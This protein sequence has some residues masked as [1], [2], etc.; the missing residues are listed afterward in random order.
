MFQDVQELRSPEPKLAVLVLCTVSLYKL[1]SELFLTYCHL[2]WRLRYH[3]GN[4]SKSVAKKVNL[5]SF[6]LYRDY[7]NLLT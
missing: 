1:T 7:F 2:I 3:D 4:G 5:C 6:N